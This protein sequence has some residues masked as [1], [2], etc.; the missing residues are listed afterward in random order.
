MSFYLLEARVDK[1][2]VTELGSFIEIEISKYWVNRSQ[3]GNP[4]LIF[5]MNCISDP[6]VIE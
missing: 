3:K 4:C 6:E 2:A 1:A 5:S